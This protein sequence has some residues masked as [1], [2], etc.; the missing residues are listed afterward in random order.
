MHEIST[1]FGFTT[2]QWF[3]SFCLAAVLIGVRI[4]LRIVYDALLARF[5]FE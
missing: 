5:D 3:I 4:G 1:I 2:T